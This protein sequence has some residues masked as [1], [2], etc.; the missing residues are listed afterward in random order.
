MDSWALPDITSNPEVRQIFKIRTIWKPDVFLPK[1]R[2][3]S[4]FKNSFIVN[5]PLI[6][7]PGSLTENVRTQR[8]TPAPPVR[9]A[10]AVGVDPYL[11]PSSGIPLYKYR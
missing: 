1:C 11:H 7:Y 10:S 5:N 4:T 3:F 6:N 2:T 8:K 9:Q